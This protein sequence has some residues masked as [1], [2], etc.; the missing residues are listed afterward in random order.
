MRNFAIISAAA[1]TRQPNVR[2]ASTVEIDGV[3]VRCAIVETPD[4]VFNRYDPANARRV[5][6]RIHAFSLNYRDKKFLFSMALKGPD[7]GFFPVGSELMGEVLEIGPEVTNFQ[8]GDR[9][10]GNNA[11][12]DSG[13]PG[14]RPGVITNHS[15]REMQ[16]LHEV[17][18]M[19]IP[20]GMPDDTAAAFSLGAQTSYSMIRRLQVPEG[21]KVLVTSARSNTSLFVIELLRRLRAQVYA[22][23]TSG[24]FADALLAWGAHHVIVRAPGQPLLDHPALADAIKNGGMQ[25]V[26]DPYF[27]LHFSPVLDVMGM[28]AKYITCGVQDQSSDVTGKQAPTAGRTGREFLNICVKNLQILGNCIGI[29]EDLER[30]NSDYAKGLVR[31]ALDSTYSHDEA[32]EFLD[33]T[34]N[35]PDRFGKVVYQYS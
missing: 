4:P 28:E 9:V 7:T 12:P 22:L 6:L 5:L 19:R 31:V 32:G 26:I 21:A 11:Y 25:Y 24:R 18:L 2:G 17:K 29:D 16:I 3:P 35:S 30:A 20:D 10:M 34:F 1:Q 23:T 13:V 15:S 14:V 27:D 33:R 8:P